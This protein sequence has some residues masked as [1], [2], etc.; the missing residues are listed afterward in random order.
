MRDT[1]SPNAS[2]QQLR[3]TIKVMTKMMDG[4][5][6]TLVEKYNLGTLQ[7]LNKESLF[8]NKQI[9]EDEKRILALPVSGAIGLKDL[10]YYFDLGKNAGP[11]Q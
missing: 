10:Q 2:P 11:A 4:A 5:L 6:E 7:N 3:G 9:L 8:A 1:V